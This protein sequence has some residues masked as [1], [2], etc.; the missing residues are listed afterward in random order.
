MGGLLPRCCTRPEAKAKPP[1]C[2]KMEVQFKDRVG[3]GHSLRKY[4]GVTKH[5]AGELH[6]TKQLGWE[7]IWEDCDTQAYNR[8]KQRIIV[9]C[10]ALIH[11]L[12]R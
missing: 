2:Q 8:A 6:S 4:F 1:E 3:K 12:R 7:E 9:S 11:A 10:K 5:L